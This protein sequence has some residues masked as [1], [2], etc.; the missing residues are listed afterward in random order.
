MKTENTS[1]FV[2]GWGHTRMYSHKFNQILLVIPLLYNTINVN[3]IIN[4]I[5]NLNLLG[6]KYKMTNVLQQVQ[7][8][9]VGVQECRQKYIRASYFYNMLADVRFNN[10]Y[11]ICA[12]QSEG[13]KDACQGDSGGPLMLPVHED[14][15]H[16]FYQIG[17]VSWGMG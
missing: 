7:V 4:F 2:A 9:M 13:G 12:G 8:L 10:S 11:V 3:H 5:S 6:E 14:G 16:Y 1:P 15:R 17:I